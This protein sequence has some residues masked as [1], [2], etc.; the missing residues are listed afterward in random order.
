[1]L[2]VT[3]PTETLD[4]LAVNVARVNEEPTSVS[5]PVL[6]AFTLQAQSVLSACAMVSNVTGPCGIFAVKYV[7]VEEVAVLVVLVVNVSALELSVVVAKVVEV[8]V[9]VCVE[10]DDVDDMKLLT[11][12]DVSL[13]LTAAVVAVVAV[14]DV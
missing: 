14:F 2:K 6:V 5:A 13:A 11:R 10:L 12:V 7:I 1:M 8:G 3:T 9:A 4:A